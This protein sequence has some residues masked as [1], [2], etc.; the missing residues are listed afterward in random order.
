M[1]RYTIELDLKEFHT[2]VYGDFIEEI[3][4]VEFQ[5][6]ELAEKS[7]DFTTLYTKGEILEKIADQLREFLERDFY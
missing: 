7:P 6:Q 5:I 2:L 4:A 1:A 3:E